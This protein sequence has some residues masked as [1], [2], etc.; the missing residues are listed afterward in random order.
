MP[1]NP[2]QVTFNTEAR[3]KIM[4]GARYLAKAVG[5]TLSPKGRN[6]T[7]KGQ[8]SGVKT[9]HDGVTVANEIK[10]K[11]PQLDAGVILLRDAARKTN[12]ISGDGT[13]TATVLG[14]AIAEEG[15]K[16]IIAGRNPMLMVKG[17]AKA[18]KI[19]VE[20]LE[21]IAEPIKGD[22]DKMIAVATVSAADEEIGTKIAEA[23]KKV[24]EYG[25]VTVDSGS[26]N[27]YVVEY[28]D[29][30]EWDKGWIHPAF[31]L[32]MLDGKPNFKMEARIE[33]PYILITDYAITSNDEIV[34][35]LTK[36]KSAGIKNLVVISD[37]VEREAMA[38]LAENFA[39]GNFNI[40]PVPAPSFGNHKRD[41]LEDLAILT[42]GK[43]ISQELK[44]KLADMTIEDLGRADLVTAT[45]ES[46]TLVGG[47]GDI[48]AI[49]AR[50]EQLEAQVK[51]EAHEYL[52]ERVKERLAKLTSGV[53]VV[54]VGMA[55]DAER[56]EKIERVRDAIGATKAATEKGIIAGGGVPLLNIAKKLPS[57]APLD[58]SEEEEL[59]FQILAEA[60]KAP[61]KLIAENSGIKGDVVISELT[62]HPEGFGY[63]VVAGKYVDL[64]KAGI[65]DPVKVTI[66]AVENASSV[67][68]NIMTSEALVTDIEEEPAA[69]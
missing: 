68:A 27:G 9:V 57:L 38:L 40:L 19:V 53:A 48:E 55:S 10:L 1:V 4:E 36:L 61:I 32:R 41:G 39:R 30:M 15:N 42:G 17:L 8:Y 6:V 56:D 21:K 31:V 64:K 13:T 37:G 26:E 63:D 59:G 2:K 58:L 62:H 18:A 20:E 35:I 22:L 23:L 46:T 49:K 52:R 34:P 3:Q 54:K 60:L 7:L 25:V 5:T 67:A 11:D 65:L 47:K 51:D 33:D 44:M 69:K 43:F 45:I 28:K 12:D 24:G 14:Y 50:A 66:S 16:H 29:G